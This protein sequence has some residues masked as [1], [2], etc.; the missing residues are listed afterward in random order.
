MVKKILIPLRK[1]L[2]LSLPILFLL[3]SG[4]SVNAAPKIQEPAPS[5]FVEVSEPYEMAV[6]QAPQVVRSRF[7][8]VNFRLLQGI[9]A[10]SE[11]ELNLFNNVVFDAVIERIEPTKNG[12]TLIGQL[13]DVDF[14]RVILVVGGGQITGNVTMP[15]GFHHIRNA[16]DE[17][18]LI[19]QIDQS[20]YPP[21]APPIPVEYPEGMNAQE[22]V[23]VTADDGSVIDVLVVYTASARSEVGGTSQMMN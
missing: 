4:E 9:E 12:Y 15:E 23:S 11:V 13:K 21:E 7:V 2:A 1:I 8:K 22:G 6:A 17:V 19:E 18:H 16:G 3:L 20:L 5:L 14:S 10:S